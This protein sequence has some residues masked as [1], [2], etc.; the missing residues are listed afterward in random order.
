M[1]PPHK[2]RPERQEDFL[3]QLLRS[4]LLEKLEQENEGK[5]AKALRSC[6]VELPLRCARCGNAH[7]ATTHCKKKWCPVCARIVAARNKRRVMEVVSKFQWP[8]MVTLTSRNTPTPAGLKAFRE[9]F[10]RFRRWKIWTK[11]VK[12]G[13]CGYE[14]TSDGSTFHPHG[15]MIIDCRWLAIETKEPDW[16]GHPDQIKYRCMLAHDEFSRAWGKCLKQGRG[17][18]VWIKRVSA[19]EALAEC[20]KYSLK[21]SDVLETEGKAGPL[22][23]AVDS[24]RCM[25]TFG[26]GY[27]LGKDDKG[28]GA[29]CRNCGT[30]GHI[31][32]ED[33]FQAAMRGERSK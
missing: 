4:Q 11:T 13:V 1:K 5:L 10:T 29:E 33:E 2:Q 14:M 24:I 17:A 32:T 19:A 18:V 23:R 12:G 21:T 31:I 9:A 30:K 22:I 8:L 15:H 16:K 27:K 3:P 26:K 20:L 7:V 28:E 25:T 6:G